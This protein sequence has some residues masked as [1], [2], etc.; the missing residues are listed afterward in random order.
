MTDIPIPGIKRIS[1][2][3]Q[4]EA[5]LAT[6]ILEGRMTAEDAAE[7]MA[8]YLMALWGDDEKF[9]PL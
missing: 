9:W 4:L 2:F 3:D 8:A 1:E 7:C 6:A 5:N